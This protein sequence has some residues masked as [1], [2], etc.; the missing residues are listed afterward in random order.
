MTNF[1]LPV[2]LR[3][4]TARRKQ[5]MISVIT[6]ISVIGVAAGVMALIV[7]LAINNG[8]R[9]TL[10]RNLLGAMAHV[11]VLEKNP[12]YG[13][14]GWREVLGKVS[15]LPE[16]VEASPTLYGSV[17]L[18]SPTQPSG[19]V[20]K[21]IPPENLERFELL[22]KLK[23]GAA[24]NWSESRGRP[25]IILG[26]RLAENTG[27]KVGDLVT[28]LSPQGEL[29]PFG[30]RPSTHYFRLT[31]IFES[32][33]H[34]LDSTW[35]FTTLEAMQRVLGVDDV[36]NAI[37]LRIGDIDRAGE[38][39]AAVERVAGPKLGATTWM[40]QN[41]H[42]LG[43][44]RM[45][46]VVTVITIGLIQMV[47]ALNILISLVMMVMEKH[48]DIALLMSMGARPRQIRNIFLLEGALIGAAGTV[49]G[50]IGGYGLS[51]LADRHQWIRLDQEVY[52]LSYVPFEPRFIDGLWVPVA[53]IA[54]SL[55][56]TLYPARSATR[57]VP[58]EALR[59]E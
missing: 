3:Y 30:A 2:A 41:R 48:R 33:F 20:L 10:Q 26:A 42:I 7:A 57:I 6:A 24:A 16:V 17:Y 52:A 8:F 31:G 59:Y 49:I 51:Y 27:F 29:T 19:A 44:L 35:A 46:R 36:V 25:G 4:L 45:E 23:H 56:A 53:A 22:R 37:E 21:G 54:V 18:P 28:V 58:A 1:E 40:E 11:S 47:A 14:A 34:D 32:G 12:V 38:V 43:A 13:I 15:R 50:L 5:A 9:G 39:A 55:L